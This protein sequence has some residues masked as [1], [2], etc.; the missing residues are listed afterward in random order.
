MITPVVFLNDYLMT[1][2]LSI[3]SLLSNRCYEVVCMVKVYRCKICGEGILV[4]RLLRIALFAGRM[5]SIL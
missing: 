4:I 3:N 5:R 1:G 2:K